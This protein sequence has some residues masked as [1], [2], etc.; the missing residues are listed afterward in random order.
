[1]SL[2]GIL[3]TLLA[4]E[5]IPQPA[6]PAIMEALESIEVTHSDEAHSGF[7]MTL[8]AG[9]Q[10]RNGLRDYPLLK[11]STLN[12]CSRVIMIVTFKGRSY[13]IMDGIITTHELA[14]G[15]EP[16]SSTLRITG[17]DI[18]LMMDRE[19]KSAPHPAQDEA[20]IARNI[21]S[22]YAKYGMTAD[23][24]NPPISDSPTPNER[25][26]IQ[27]GTDLEHL[28]AMANRYAYVFYVIPGPVPQS[29]IAY[30]GPPRRDD[31]T[32]PAIFVGTG[33]ESCVDSVSF[34]NNSLAAVRVQGAVQDRATN[35]SQ[36]V[37][38][39]SPAQ[40]S[41]SSQPALET[42]TCIRKKILRGQ[43][44]LNSSQATA[45]AQA[46]SDSSNNAVSVQGELDTQRYGNLLQA[47]GVVTVKGAGYC[48]DGLYYVKKVTH[49][50]SRGSYRQRFTLTR[51]GLGSTV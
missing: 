41:L 50:I 5:N 23:V 16:G 25:V 1:M 49:I 15:N 39:S 18:S 42:Q 37:Q 12:P 14:P 13:V 19:E 2:P 29:S 35:Q 11:D 36:K 48:Y 46:M 43:E 24:R 30:W 28:K 31:P 40:P 21:I 32:Q 33:P 22:S 51:D 34:Q 20:A 26:P 7:Q 27:Q 17:E 45:K 8:Q 4:G 44:G 3:F 47:R 10:A 6:S 38:N 9:R